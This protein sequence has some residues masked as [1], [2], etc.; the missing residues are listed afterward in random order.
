MTKSSVVLFSKMLTDRQSP[1]LDRWV[2]DS[3]YD[4]MRCESSLVELV[5]PSASRA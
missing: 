4:A 5:V 2:R 3:T 1:E